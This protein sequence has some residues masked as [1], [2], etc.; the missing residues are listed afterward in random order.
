MVRPH[1]NP[2]CS[3]I[4]YRDPARSFSNR[5]VEIQAYAAA[6][7]DGSGGGD[8]VLLRSPAR[9]EAP[10]SAEQAAPPAAPDGPQGPPPG[11]PLSIPPRP[12]V[13]PP[14]RSPPARPAP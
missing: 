9:G 10:P 14:A 4:E 13:R 8:D 6:D 3:R 2:C 11:R 1:G 12:P 5:D 7:M